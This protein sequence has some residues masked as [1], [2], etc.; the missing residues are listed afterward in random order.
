VLI[1]E[2]L[3]AKLFC[4]PEAVNESAWSPDVKCQME[5][6]KS[7]TDPIA[8]SNELDQLVVRSV[9]QLHSTSH[10]PIS[11][12]TTG[13]STAIRSQVLRG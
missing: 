4:R 12:S 10:T 3:T 7:P 2:D 6:A 13:G 5:L 11:H 8:K 1:Q 9:S